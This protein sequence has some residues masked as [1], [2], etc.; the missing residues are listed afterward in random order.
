[1]FVAYIQYK[2]VTA[3]CFLSKL[4]PGSMFCNDFLSVFPAHKDSDWLCDIDTFQ[5]VLQFL[6]ICCTLHCGLQRPWVSEC[7]HCRL[8]CAVTGSDQTVELTDDGTRGRPEVCLV[9]HTLRDELRKFCPLRE[10]QLLES[11]V[12]MLL[13]HSEKDKKE[14]KH[15]WWRRISVF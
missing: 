6:R 11:L 7:R 8:W 15:V 13:L 14:R 5:C 10:R 1:M 4:N 9:V 2:F 3:S 12:K